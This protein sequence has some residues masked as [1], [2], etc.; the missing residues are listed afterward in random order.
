[1]PF[2]A[3]AIANELLDRAADSRSTLT[4]INIQ[5]LVY[6]AH[7]WNL[8]WRNE[9]LILESI[10]AWQYG[11]VVRTLY[12][13]FRRFGSD[14]ITDRA[15]DFRIDSNGKFVTPIA[16]IDQSEPGIDAR[17]VVGAIWQQ[18][19]SLKPFQLVE[20]THAPNSPWEKSWSS[21]QSVIPNDE[22]Q[23]YFKGLMTPA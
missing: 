4:Q 3:T 6:F 21:K 19:G 7:G 22:I 20:L 13:Q 18:Y 10:E 12:D 9:P 2:T 5:K 16:A 11:P 17:N 15:R 23:R 8:A 1:M 14:P